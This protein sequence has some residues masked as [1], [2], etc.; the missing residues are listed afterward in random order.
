M[1]LHVAKTKQHIRFSFR[2][3][4]ALKSLEELG[5]IQRE[6]MEF[7][8]FWLGGELGPKHQIQDFM[9]Y[10]SCQ[11]ELVNLFGQLTP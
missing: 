9:L 8:D 2:W 6:F 4:P 5:E 3:F 7:R 10:Q 11:N 1:E